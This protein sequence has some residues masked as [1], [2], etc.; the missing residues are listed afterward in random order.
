MELT[1]RGSYDPAVVRRFLC[2]AATAA[3]GLAIAGSALAVSPPPG[4]LCRS[5]P[6]KDAHG[7]PDITRV[8]VGN[9]AKGTIALLADLAPPVHINQNSLV[10]FSIDADCKAKTGDASGFD[11]WVGT[12]GH[13]VGA[14]RVK[15]RKAVD[16]P[17]LR[18]G[19]TGNQLFLTVNRRD[20]KITRCVRTYAWSQQGSTYGD[21]APNGT[22]VLTYRLETTAVAPTVASAGSSGTN[23][24]AI[25]ALSL[26]GA[27]LLALI[28]INILKGKSGMAAIG[29]IVH[30]TWYVGAIR[31]A[32]PG[33]WWDR[34]FYKG[35]RESK[36]TRAV[37]RHGPKEQPT[38]APAAPPRE[39][40][41]RLP[42]PERPAPAEPGR[43]PE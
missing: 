24:G 37:G 4:S 38:A 27:F 19:V 41:D 25:V 20:L 11:Y 33:S 31:L 18:G 8:C 26:L 2:V 3:M 42:F 22:A 34:H 10:V 13:D 7:A 14:A 21:D 12:A 9:D 36:H 40:S 17:S 23:V 39:G 28:V 29:I 30:V 5:D 16:L 1:A 15:P 43:T 6:A 32:K 35:T